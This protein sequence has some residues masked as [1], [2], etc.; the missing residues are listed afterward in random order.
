VKGKLIVL[1]GLDGSGT[2]T[3]MACVAEY[4]K[5]GH[6]VVTNA[7]PSSGPVGRFI[8]RELLP[9]NCEPI[10]HAATA[11]L[12]AA[13]RADNIVKHV[14]PAMEDGK[15]VISDRWYYSS[16]AYQGRTHK[17]RIGAL[18][19]NLGWLG[20]ADRTVTPDLVIFIDVS[21]EE[22]AQ[23]RQAAGR[24]VELYD[25]I[26]TQRRVRDGYLWAFEKLQD[27]EKIVYVDGEQSKEDVTKEILKFVH[28]V[29]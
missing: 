6:S 17:E 14:R 5:I 10:D 22:A 7:Q 4:L 2:T 21:P 9:G 19:L 12:F 3:Q 16:I 25:D 11:L 29:I 1:E 15:I 28:E 20:E 8:R 18:Y 26:E 24:P 27:E 23:R 13:D